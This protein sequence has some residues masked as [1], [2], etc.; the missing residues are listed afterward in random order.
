MTYREKKAFYFGRFPQAVG[1]NNPSA[2]KK[3][4]KTPRSLKDFEVFAFGAAIQIRT[5]DLILTKDALYQ[6][7]YSSTSQ[8]D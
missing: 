6:L 2:L 1:C 8:L 7:S 3:R 4:K 5:G